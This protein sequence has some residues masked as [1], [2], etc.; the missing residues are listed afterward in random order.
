MNDAYKTPLKSYRMH[1]PELGT[2]DNPAAYVEVLGMGEE[3]LPQ[4]KK[5]GWIRRHATLLKSIG[6]SLPFLAAGILYLRYHRVEQ[7]TANQIITNIRFTPGHLVVDDQPFD[8]VLKESINDR[9]HLQDKS[10][11]EYYLVITNDHMNAHFFY[12]DHESRFPIREN[13]ENKL[14]YKCITRLDETNKSFA[15]VQDIMFNGYKYPATRRNNIMDVVEDD[16]WGKV[17]GDIGPTRFVHVQKFQENAAGAFL[18]EKISAGKYK[19]YQ[20]RLG[21][22]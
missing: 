19:E 16:F 14:F 21:H 22:Y 9:H 7:Q 8:G 10:D 20:Q 6:Y 17:K 11:K 5:P 3:E 2:K 18:V 12:K 4:P 13:L 15:R 1:D